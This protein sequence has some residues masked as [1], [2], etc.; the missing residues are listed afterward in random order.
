MQ[1]VNNLKEVFLNQKTENEDFQA[2][3]KSGK[4]LFR[5][6]CLALGTMSVLAVLMILPGK[7]TEINA[8]AKKDMYIFNTEF[9]STYTRV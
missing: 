9:E 7:A 8:S 5:I 1:T 6:L 3:N 4:G 2:V